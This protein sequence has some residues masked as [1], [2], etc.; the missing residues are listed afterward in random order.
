MKKKII[1]TIILILCALLCGGV[2]VYAG[3][4]VY[5]S[6]VK[7]KNSTVDEALDQLYCAAKEQQSVIT[8]DG[9]NVSATSNTMNNVGKV[10]L[11]KGTYLVTAH[12]NYQ[13]NDL[14]Y[15]IK[16]D[17][18]AASAHDSKGYVSMQ[19][20]N[21]INVTQ[22]DYDVIFYVYPSDRTVTLA[23]VKIKAVRLY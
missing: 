3:T 18:Y 5:A 21:I 16:L 6:Q 2:G 19:I 11:N 15:Y 23:T 12:A 8:F 4:T 13:G 20:T 14:R 10:T 22:D 1:F 7:Y 9:T 17:D